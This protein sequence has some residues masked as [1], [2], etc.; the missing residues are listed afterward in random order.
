MRRAL[1]ASSGNVLFVAGFPQPSEKFFPD[2]FFSDDDLLKPTAEQGAAFNPFLRF[3]VLRPACF[4]PPLILAVAVVPG[5]SDHGFWAA[6]IGEVAG[7]LAVLTPSELSLQ[8]Q[9][10][11]SL[12][13]LNK[14]FGCGLV[15]WKFIWD[16]GAH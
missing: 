2:K 13:H 5:G 15:V 6:V 11:L 8:V 14:R 16:D 3:Q 1:A 12:G 10:G 9:G 7:K 4:G